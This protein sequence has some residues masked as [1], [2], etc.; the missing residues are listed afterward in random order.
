MIVN[1]KTLE[2]RA[3]VERYIRE[4][5]TVSGACGASV[6]QQEI[7]SEQQANFNQMSNQAA[8]VFGDT[9]QVFKELQSSFAPI[10]AAGPGQ[11]GFTAP[12]L[13]NL[14]SQ[15]VTA[16]G[17][18][19]RNA[20]QAVGE[21]M[22]AAGGGTTVLPSG[23]AMAEQGNIAEEGAQATA[24]QLS[25]INLENAQLGQ[26]NWMNAAGVLGGAA[27]TFNAS[28]GA[29]KA[30]TDS[31]SAAM[32]GASTVQQANN[33]WAQDLVSIASS[34]GQVAGNIMCP[35]EG[36][37]YLMADGTEKPVED[38][39]VGELLAGIDDEPQTIEEIQ[40]QYTNIIEVT[41][42]NG[43]VT[44]NSP[45]HAFALP[46]GGFV[47]SIRSLGKTILTQTGP[48]KVTKIEPA[49]K[50]WVFNV[51]T[52]GSHTYRA[53]GVWSLG[54]GDAER[55][56]GMNEWARLGNRM[57]KDKTKWAAVGVN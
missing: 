41:T 39:E 50:A 11:S 45:V 27:N 14:Q 52:N 7:A 47:V 3:R 26:Q 33:Q 48:S 35:A 56:I 5:R 19:T 32:Q 30:A 24:G 1:S 36:S 44:R 22:A 31:G 4:G 20:Q 54:V 43:F 57:L 53:S 15:A 28:T 6:Q 2:H 37:P 23:A 16:G 40:S 25:N 38:L 42:E 34:G 9:S 10:L 17:V 46:K 51:I 13:A 29:G 21:R 12:E 49:G 18:A 55:H 8:A